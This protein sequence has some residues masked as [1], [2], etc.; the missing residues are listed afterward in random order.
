MAKLYSVKE[1][2]DQLNAE[3]ELHSLDYRY[4]EERVRARLRYA[5]TKNLITPKRMGYDRRAKYYT[6]EDVDKLRSL[7]VGPML[8]EFETYEED[9]QAIDPDA[10]EIEIRTAKAEDIQAILGLLPT[11]PAEAAD[12]STYLAKMFKNSRNANFVAIRNDDEIVGWS[13]AEVSPA[14]SALEGTVT[15]LIRIR[16]P[17]DRQDK[18]IA[19]RSLIYRAEW[20]LR[21][22]SVSRILLEVP[23]SMTDLKEW[24]VESVFFE[25]DHSRFL[26]MKSA[27]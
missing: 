13:Q 26:L 8:P 19:A 4:T 21:D 2:T 1:I 15:G 18:K 22:L 16:V 5:R 6:E 12:L 11:S 9:L 14:V 3:L 20:W 17:Q 23:A 24:L 27:K 7:W 25:E 10:E